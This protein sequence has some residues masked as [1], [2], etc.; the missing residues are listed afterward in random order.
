MRSDGDMLLFNPSIPEAWKAYSF[1][2][3]YRGAILEVSVT[4]ENTTF[5]TINGLGADVKIYGKVHGV[6]PQDLVVPLPAEWR[7]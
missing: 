4:K 7:G 5:R 2:V 3:L 1:R 6:G